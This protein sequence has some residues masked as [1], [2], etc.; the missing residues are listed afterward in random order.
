V[1]IVPAEPLPAD[2]ALGD[3]AWHLDPKVAEQVEETLSTLTL[4]R[5]RFLKHYLESGSIGGSVRQA[6]YNVTTSGS[7]T[8]LGRTLLKDPRVEFCVQAI[9]EAE[10]VG[11]GAKLRAVIGQ[12]MARFDSPDGGDRDRSL[13]AASLVYKLA[14]RAAPPAVNA[15]GT[16]PRGSVDQLLDQMTQEELRRLADHGIWP[17]RLAHFLRAT[18]TD[19]PLLDPPPEP[20]SGSPA[21]DPQPPLP[22]SHRAPQRTAERA[23]PVAVADYDA[24]QALIEQQAED[25]RRALHAPLPPELREMAARDRRW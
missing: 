7:A 15:S 3:P 11:S 1:E 4:R 22:R 2:K 24:R 12:H 14:H 18:T 21:S 16:G 8:E 10:G 5:R 19:P 13:R 20:E 23:E 17:R 25:L 9:L 6:G